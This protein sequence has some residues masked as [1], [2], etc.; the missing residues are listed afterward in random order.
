MLNT[1]LYIQYSVTANLFEKSQ[2]NK[3]NNPVF[4]G[5]KHNNMNIIL[6]AKNKLKNLDRVKHLG[7]AS[8]IEIKETALAK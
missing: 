3:G 2:F 5:S 8:N 6:V 1:F 7:F 4:Y